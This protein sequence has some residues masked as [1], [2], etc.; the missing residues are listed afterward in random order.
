MKLNLFDKGIGFALLNDIAGISK[1]EERLRKS[2]MID[3]DPTNSLTGKFQR[4]LC[5]RR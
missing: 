4:P 1:I 5:K 2:K 3:Y